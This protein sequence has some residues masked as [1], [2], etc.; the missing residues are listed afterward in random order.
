[1]IFCRFVCVYVNSCLCVCV[2]VSIFDWLFIYLFIIIDMFVCV[3]TLIRVRMCMYVCLLF[4]IN[5]LFVFVCMHITY[6][7]VHVNKIHA[8]LKHDPSFPSYHGLEESCLARSSTMSILTC[9][10]H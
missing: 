3:F 9:V 6:T 4:I 1:M 10:W 5:F 8:L 2:C 7:S